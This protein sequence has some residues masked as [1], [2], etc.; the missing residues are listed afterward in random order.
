MNKQTTKVCVWENINFKLFHNVQTTW[1]ILEIESKIRFGIIPRMPWIMFMN[2]F[3][4]SPYRPAGENISLA[5][6]AVMGRHMFCTGYDTW[7]VLR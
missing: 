5:C 6:L 3:Y 1:S 7:D 2:S 4:K